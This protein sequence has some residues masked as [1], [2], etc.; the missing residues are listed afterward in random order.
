M[1]VVEVRK[2]R[3]IT[4]TLGRESTPLSTDKSSLELGSQ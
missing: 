4:D 1:D 2:N 3:G